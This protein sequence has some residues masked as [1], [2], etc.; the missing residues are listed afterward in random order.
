MKTIEILE[1]VD[2]NPSLK[3]FNEMLPELTP[4]STPTGK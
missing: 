1:R 3:K 4:V 2:D